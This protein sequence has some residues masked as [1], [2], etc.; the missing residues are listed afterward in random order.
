MLAAALWTLASA[1]TQ[2]VAATQPP[3]P[4]PPSLVV[5]G[6]DAFRPDYLERAN[7]PAIR[8]LAARGVRAQGLIPPFPSKTFPSFVTIATGLRPARHGILNNTIDDPA[9]PV[10]FRLSDHPGRSD[11]RW[12]LG[13]PI[14]NTAERQGVRAAGIFWP[15][16]DAEILGR[17]PSSY[18]T[19]D[20][21]FPN[22][23][24][25]DR[26]LSLLAEP[27]ATRPWL[28]MLYV[29]LVDD[30]SHAHGP[31]APEAHAA[32]AAADA[33]VARLL[34]G[35]ES[36][37]LTSTVNVAVVSDHG[38]AETTP[39][40]VIVLDDYVDPASVDVIET[41]PS[42]RLRPLDEATLSLEERRR[43]TVQTLRALRGKHPRLRVY[44]GTALPPRFQAGTSVRIPPVVGMADDGWLVLT[45]EQLQRWR[46]R[47]GETRGEHGFAPGLPSMHGVFVAAGPS[48]R[49]GMRLPAVESI[50]LYEAFCRVLRITPGPNDGDPRVLAG[51]TR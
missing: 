42:V 3:P 31:H 1:G 23:Q 5:V 28:V 35:L 41:G 30:A 36:R 38:M 16:D 6:I 2:D 21:S 7:V 20:E 18:L 46:E 51:A 33:L 26:A 25:I 37:G 22:E 15:G 10:R 40:R 8:A 11:P 47:G 34:A 17:R 29:S 27:A 24:R 49:V 19:Y 43:W 4:P 39:D 14:W 12:W 44:P 9:I 45:R 32:A 13:E 48:F 50:H